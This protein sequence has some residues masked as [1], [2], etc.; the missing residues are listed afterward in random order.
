[1]EPEHREDRRDVERRKT[2]H[3]EPSAEHATLTTPLASEGLE[4]VRDSHC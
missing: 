1:M 3:S 4:Q 2:E